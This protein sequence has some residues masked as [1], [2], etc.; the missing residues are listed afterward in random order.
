MNF[1]FDQ[2]KSCEP[3]RLDQQRFCN[4]DKLYNEDLIYYRINESDEL[5]ASILF[6]DEADRIK[7]SVTVKPIEGENTLRSLRRARSISPG[8]YRVTTILV[9]ID[10][11]WLW[12]RQVAENFENEYRDKKVYVPRHIERIYFSDLYVNSYVEGGYTF[13]QF[14]FH[15]D[16]PLYLCTYSKEAT[17]VFSNDKTEFF[18]Y[19][20]IEKKSNE[21]IDVILPEGL[22]TIHNYAFMNAKIETLRIP[23]S[24]TEIGKKAFLHAHIKT[25]VFEGQW[26]DNIDPEA[27]VDFK[28]EEGIRINDSAQNISSYNDLFEAVDEDC[29]KLTLAAP[30]LCK[31]ESPT[32]GYIRATQVYYWEGYRRR[33][34]NVMHNEGIVDI[35]TRYIVSVKEYDIPTY[36][37]IKGSIITLFGFDGDCQ[38]YSVIVYEP[39]EMVLEKI[40]TAV[41]QINATGCTVD[42]LIDRIKNRIK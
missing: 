32:I 21:Y 20:I 31:E 8:D 40:D 17:G 15:E 34:N 38:H 9:N 30:R 41:R 4:T 14:I 33:W 22:K 11:K 35:N 7:E 6:P 36:T 3:V 12:R 25:I 37:P 16:T 18:F 39:L 1:T 2:Q 28:C 23:A 26:T 42:E 13:P 5:C 19:N 10:P 27:F 29:N 24:V